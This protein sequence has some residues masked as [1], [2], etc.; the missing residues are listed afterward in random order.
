MKILFIGGLKRDD[1]T[2][3]NS[4]FEFLALKKLFKNIEIL[5]PDKFFLLPSISRR[6]FYH[7][8]PKILEPLL[9]NFFLSNIK[10]NYDLI[11]VNST[12]A[13]YI[14]KKLIINLKKK[15]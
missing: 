9:N 5:D 8:S 2:K 7:L 15:M 13:S 10:D 11:Y 12:S 3:K 14:G 6:I 1:G 4:Y